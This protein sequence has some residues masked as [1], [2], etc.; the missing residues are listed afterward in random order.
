MS[1]NSTIASY[2]RLHAQVYD[3]TRWSFLFGRDQLLQLAGSI[4]QPANVLEVGCGTGRNLAK[5]CTIF[6]EAKLTGIDLSTAMLDKAW[7]NLRRHSGRIKLINEAYDRPLCGQGTG[8]DLIVCSYALSMFNPGWEQAIDSALEDLVPGGLFALVDFHNTPVPDFRRWM[9]RNHVEMNAHLLPKLE[10]TFQ[11]L[12]S[13][14]SSA[15][16][17][18]WE[19]VT[20]VGRRSERSA[21]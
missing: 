18:L 7:G 21:L 17:G 14:T 9:Q 19:Y 20:F 11:P 15:Y 4:Q 16:G 3:A 2:Y 12:L 13:H 8:F 6:P 1:T 5:L 10:Q